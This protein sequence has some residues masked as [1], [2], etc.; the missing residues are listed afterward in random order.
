MDGKLVIFSAPSGAGKTTLVK[1]LLEDNPTLEFSISAASRPMRPGEVEG[2]HYYFM[3]ADEFRA[4][5]DADEFVEWE[6]VYKDQYYGTLKKEVER[7][8]AKGNHVIFDVDVVGGVNI[9]KMYGEKA[10][11]I[12]VMPP[13]VEVLK[14]RLLGRS[15]ETEESLKKR[16][17]KAEFELTFADKFDEEVVND[18][19]QLA[20][21]EASALVFSFL[22][23]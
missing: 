23:N 3:S 18:D 4:K 20:I 21:D 1:A 10:L 7:I 22:E 11:S 9:K 8:W 19:L 17:D 15:T 16:L 2:T 13:S 6:E 5:I 14:E 12:F